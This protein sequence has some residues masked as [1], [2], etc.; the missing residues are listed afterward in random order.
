MGELGGLEIATVVVLRNDR[1]SGCNDFQILSI[2]SHRYA[3]GG[4][5]QHHQAA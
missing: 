1:Q 4:R 3:A 2:H 5:F